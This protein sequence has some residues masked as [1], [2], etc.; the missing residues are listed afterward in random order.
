MDDIPIAVILAA[1]DN[2]LLTILSI[3]HLLYDVRF[4]L[5]L[6]DREDPT[7]AIGH[8][9]RPRFLSY[10]D[11]DFREVTAVLG[12]MIGGFYYQRKIGESGGGRAHAGPAAI[13]PQPHYKKLASQEGRDIKRQPEHAIK[14]R[15]NSSGGQDGVVRDGRGPKRPAGRAPCEDGKKHAWS[16]GRVFLEVLMKNCEREGDRLRKALADAY[17]RVIAGNGHRPDGRP[18]GQATGED[19]GLPDHLRTMEA[20]GQLADGIA[21]DYG[22]VLA[23]VMGYGGYMNQELDEKDPMR[24]YVQRILASSEKVATLTRGL[25][26]FARKQVARPKRTDINDVIRRAGRLVARVVGEGIDFRTRLSGRRLQVFADPVQLEQ[27]VMNVAAN[28]RD[29]MAAG[30]TLTVETKG[31]ASAARPRITGR[32][33]GSAP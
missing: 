16:T 4:I 25:L 5:V 32:A 12:K 29:A 23:L 31:C 14:V 6:P 10:T 33:S 22:R 20:A 8:S 15:R 1:S 13:G 18:K 30:G 9:L 28:A 27:V 11:S 19:A 21:Q 7:V 3:S 26:A 17:C 2:D 24:S